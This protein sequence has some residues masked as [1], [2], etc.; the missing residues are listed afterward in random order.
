MEKLNSPLLVYSNCWKRK[1]KKE[2]TIGWESN[3]QQT[4]ISHNSG[5]WEYKNQ[6]ISRVVSSEALLLGL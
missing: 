5:G 3:K 1:R 2:T 6:G 4:C